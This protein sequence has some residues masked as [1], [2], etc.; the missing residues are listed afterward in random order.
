MRGRAAA[1]SCRS[2]AIGSATRSAS[3][4]DT[5]ELPSGSPALHYGAG[6]RGAGAGGGVGDVGGEGDGG[7]GDGGGGCGAGGCGFGKVGPVLGLGG[8]PVASAPSA[9]PPASRP[10]SSRIAPSIIAAP[11]PGP[12]SCAWSSAFMP[13]AG[14]EPAAKHLPRPRR[15]PRFL[16]GPPDRRA[17]RCPRGTGCFGSTPAISVFDVP[18]AARPPG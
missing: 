5:R 17:T 10:A 2:L 6:S 1:K 3:E 14:D 16:H 12:R 7:E 4:C 8:S 11:H 15:S 9:V 13:P 18:P